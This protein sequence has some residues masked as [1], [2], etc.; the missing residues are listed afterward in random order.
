MLYV[1]TMNWGST[2]PPCLLHEKLPL[3]ISHRLTERVHWKIFS[4]SFI[5]ATNKRNQNP[6][7]QRNQSSEQVLNSSV[8]SPGL[9]GKK[10]Y[11]Y[12]LTVWTGFFAA[13]SKSLAD[14]HCSSIFIDSN[15]ISFFQITGNIIW[16]IQASFPLGQRSFHVFH[17]RWKKYKSTCL[18][19]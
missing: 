17:K 16:C 4:Q 9:P 11:S 13:E 8:N 18:N 10:G 1:L 6:T 15:D 19:N 5:S 14:A 2:T 3:C 12:K 7:N